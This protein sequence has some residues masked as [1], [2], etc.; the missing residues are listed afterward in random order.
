LRRGRRF[1]TKKAVT[2]NVILDFFM[3]SCGISC[4]QSELMLSAN[5]PGMLDRKQLQQP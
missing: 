5:K 4:L 2:A 1:F 3:T